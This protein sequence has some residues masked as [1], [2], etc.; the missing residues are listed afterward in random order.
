MPKF[1]LQTSKNDGTYRNPYKPGGYGIRYS[2]WVT[3][4]K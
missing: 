1:L 3:E 2:P 4:Q